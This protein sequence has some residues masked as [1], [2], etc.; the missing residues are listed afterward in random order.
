MKIFVFL[1]VA[2]AFLVVRADSPGKRAM[3]DS[4]ITFQDV[5]KL[6]GYDLVWTRKYDTSHIIFHTDTSLILPS[7]GGAPDAAEVWGINKTTGQNTDTIFFENYYSP[8][9]VIIFDTLTNGKLLYQK[10]TLSNA[11]ETSSS[12]T[13]GIANKDLIKEAETARTDHNTKITILAVSS[14]LALTAIIFFFVHR[15]NKNKRNNHGTGS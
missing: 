15:R 1:F 9:Y 12:D 3:S 8:D 4:K 11:N 2:F 7:S 13:S 6:G 14:V 10:R 5:A